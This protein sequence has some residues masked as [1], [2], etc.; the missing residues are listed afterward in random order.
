MNYNSVVAW[1]NSLEEY[2]DYSFT[3]DRVEIYGDG[4][5]LKDTTNDV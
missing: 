2:L 5:E 3:L 1:S 4:A